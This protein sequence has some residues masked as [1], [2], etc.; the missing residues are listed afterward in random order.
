MKEDSPTVY[1]V[2]HIDTEGP[3]HE[4]MQEVFKRIET[5]LGVSLNL[6]P[7]PQNLKKIQAGQLENVSNSI[8]DAARAIADPHLL[9][10]KSSWSEVDEML[11]RMMSKDYRNSLR[12]SFG[13]GW[14][15]NWHIL[16][17]VGFVTNERRRDLGYLNIFNHYEQ[18]LKET[19]SAQD[20]LHWHFHPLPFFREAHIPATSYDNSFYELHQV[21]CRRLIEK[22]WFPRINRAGFHTV[23]PDSN[24]FLEQWIPFDASNQSM[25]E[26]N[27]QVQKDAINGRF[28]DW[29]GA[30]SDWSVY[31]PDLYDWRK[32]GDL[33]RVIAKC[34][35]LKTRFRNI[36][37]NELEIAFSKA[38]RENSGVY[39]GVTNHD[40]REM[41][42]EIEAFYQLLSNV[43]KNYPDVK[44]QFSGALGAF[45]NVLG[46]SS[47]EI[48]K[49]RIMI[50]AEIN[51][52][53][54]K[55]EVVNG[56]LFG[57][58]PYLAL[59]SSTGTYWHDNFDFGKP[60]KEFFYTFDRNTITLDAL[61]TIAI[62]AND[63]Y[64]NTSIVEIQLANA[65]VKSNKPYQQ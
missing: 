49:N 41:S 53:V 62:A 34:L 45:R 1:I 42:V 16:D 30:P 58:Q 15:Y 6:F 40:F 29:K 9:G 31:H 38:Q 24:F 47:T 56:A 3:L 64:G 2:H 50:E 33:K 37:Q 13:N 23:R 10:F 25:I 12:D 28:G 14:I 61:S 43:A 18:I 59:K 27:E 20:E 52:E 21:M 17:H 32:P 26:E 11:Y 63:K 44:F 22:H 36:S 55:V 46:Y 39:V 60:G 65:S 48:R 8:A 7:S 19:D 51:E 54:L 4:P 5:I 57:S 35:N